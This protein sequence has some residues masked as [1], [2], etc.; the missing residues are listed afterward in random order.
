MLA[1][2]L[3]LF[4]VIHVLCCFLFSGDKGEACALCD[5]VGPPGLPGPQG[6]PGPAGKNFLITQE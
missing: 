5:K 1:V 6:P 2:V 3:N 4:V